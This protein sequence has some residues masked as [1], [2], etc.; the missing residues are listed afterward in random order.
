MDTRIELTELQRLCFNCPVPHGC[1][2]NDPRCPYRLA[3]GSNGRRE[4]KRQ[5]LLYLAKNGSV[6]TRIIAEQFGWTTHEMF[7]LLNKLNEGG[8]VRRI[9]D[10]TELEW[11]LVC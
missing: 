8:F 4:D 6:P 5:I 2:E 1:N 9:E 10:G 11:R 3:L 7:Y